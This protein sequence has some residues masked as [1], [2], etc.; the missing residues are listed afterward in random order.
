M[1]WTRPEIIVCGLHESALAETKAH[2]SMKT[3]LKSPLDTRERLQQVD[4]A[5]SNGHEP[6][7]LYPNPYL[8]AGNSRKTSLER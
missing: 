7:R 4:D 1:C 6:A 8:L 2:T 5:S 3:V